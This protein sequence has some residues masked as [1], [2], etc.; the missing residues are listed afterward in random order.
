MAWGESMV[1]LV[2]L[3]ALGRDEQPLYSSVSS[4]AALLT[5]VELVGGLLRAKN[6]SALLDLIRQGFDRGE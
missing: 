6:F 2:F 4:L 1:S 5:D 3:V